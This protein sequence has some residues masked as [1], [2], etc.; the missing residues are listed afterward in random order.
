MTKFR[1]PWRW[2]QF[3]L[4]SLLLLL[5]MGALAAPFVVERLKPTAAQRP[6][7]VCEFSVG[8][9]WDGKS[10]TK[11]VRLVN[12]GKTDVL[13]LFI[14]MPPFSAAVVE[15]PRHFQLE[16][17]ESR[18][19]EVAWKVYKAQPPGPF[20]RKLFVQTWPSRRTL[21]EVNVSG[22]VMEPPTEA[23][24]IQGAGIRMRPEKDIE[25]VSLP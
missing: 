13:H 10:G 16:P 5:T 8:E 1:F 15:N 20:S 19:I 18:I 17:G 25:T 23:S 9:V 7:K 4:R 21:V 3:R 24:I 14:D 6:P 22:V 11:R 12:Q 2:H